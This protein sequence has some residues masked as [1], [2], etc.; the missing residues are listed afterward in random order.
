MYSRFLQDL[1]TQA[2]P[3]KFFPDPDDSATTSDLKSGALASG[4]GFDS[5]STD[6][7]FH[8]KLGSIKGQVTNSGFEE[9]NPGSAQSL[10][11]SS[12]SGTSKILSM[13]NTKDSPCKREVETLTD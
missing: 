4:P 8:S 9:L 13:L 12:C 2:D 10:G 1:A 6:E 5:K 7:L 11:A 3:A